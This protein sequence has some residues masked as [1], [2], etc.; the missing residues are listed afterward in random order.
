MNDMIYLEVQIYTSGSMMLF[1]C[2]AAMF[3]F[4]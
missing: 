4:S 2:F 3:F 1:S